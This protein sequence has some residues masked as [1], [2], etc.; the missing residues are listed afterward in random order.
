[1]SNKCIVESRPAKAEDASARVR[2]GIE[3]VSLSRG[4]EEMELIVLGEA[5]M[6][7]RV[8]GVMWEV[9]A[10]KSA[11]EAEPLAS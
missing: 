3:S 9:R 8:D 2:P 11:G 1:M 4:Q 5:R 7:V 6:R 10:R